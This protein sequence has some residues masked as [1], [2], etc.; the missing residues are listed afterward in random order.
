MKIRNILYAMFSGVLLLIP[1][2][3][4]ADDPITYTEVSTL[5]Y[6]DTSNATV[7]MSKSGKESHLNEVYI[8]YSD[9]DRDI[10]DGWI[11]VHQNTVIK[12]SGN[13][14]MWGHIDRYPDNMLVDDTY[15]GN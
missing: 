6:S 9:A 4:A 12:P 11:F 2:I 15:M 14:V 8:F 7:K 13:A 1:S 3:V 10:M 5:C